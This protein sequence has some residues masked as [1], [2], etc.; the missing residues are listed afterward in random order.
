[1]SKIQENTQ[2]LQEVLEILKQKTEVKP[3]LYG[4]YLLTDS[5]SL[6]PP[7]DR[8]LFTTNN[9]EVYG[10]YIEAS[11]M[12]Y[13]NVNTIVFGVNGSVQIHFDRNCYL[14]YEGIW[15]YYDGEDEVFVDVPDE[16][17]RII[18]IK[19]P[20]EVPKDIYDMFMGIVDNDQGQTSYD[21]G[22]DEGREAEYNEF[23]DTF[24]DNGNRYDYN[25]GFMSWPN[26]CYC[27]KYTIKP[28]YSN[29]LQET[30][31]YSAIE[32]TLV[33]IDLSHGTT[34]LNRSFISASALHTILKL[35]VVEATTYSQ[36][37]QNCIA[38]KNLTIEGT[39]GQNGL[40]LQWSVMLS[41]ASIESIMSHLST[42]TEA[43]SIT[44]SKTAVD[45]AFR[46]GNVIG[47]ESAD[48]KNLVLSRSKWTIN[49]V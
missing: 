41:R 10:F 37:F 9:S 30:F 16:R 13:G 42:T 5:V 40:N 31:G 8:V 34:P 17:F 26:D 29:A 20:I 6:T 33:T 46:N 24:Q 28:K 44:L 3:V 21:I 45:N 47:S 23:W 15:R 48:W 25:R 27:P 7:S 18:D 35:I 38:L 4:T 2:A 12:T 32:N 49:L 1:M 14:A 36:S 19:T 11:E 22:F 43:L 39:I